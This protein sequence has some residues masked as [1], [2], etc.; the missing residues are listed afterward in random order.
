MQFTKQAFEQG[1]PSF[2]KKVSDQLLPRIT[3]IA[4]EDME[5]VSLASMGD[6]L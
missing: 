4:K 1:N 3:A 2:V 5:K 6:G